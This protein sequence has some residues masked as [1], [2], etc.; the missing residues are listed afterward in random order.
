MNK[1]SQILNHIILYLKFYI[2]KNLAEDKIRAND[3]LLAFNF[4]TKILG[5]KKY[6]HLDTVLNYHNIRFF[7][8][9]IE[10]ALIESIRIIT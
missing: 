3:R 2:L 7:H 10:K 4:E 9:T 6:L 5:S 1:L 8:F